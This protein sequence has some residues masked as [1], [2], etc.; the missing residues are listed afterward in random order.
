MNINLRQNYGY[1]I[2]QTILIVAVIA[3]LVT[4]IIGSVA[5]DMLSRAGG[6]K[7]ASHLRQFETANGQFYAKYT[8][9]PHQAASTNSPDGIFKTLMDEAA[10]ESTFRPSNGGPDFENYI[11][12]YTLT[13]GPV[14]HTFGAGGDVTMDLSSN[15]GITCASGSQNYLVIS[16]TNVPA[17]EFME[18]DESLDGF[19]DCDNGR[20]QCNGNLLADTAVDLF[21][22][23]NSVR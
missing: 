12:S 6:T 7:L 19:P 20:L 13:G 1:T 11:P 18:T 21:Y 15:L 10:L 5:W 8:V 9:W 17:Q 23:A 4:L 22:C 2:D 16:M 3:L 14:Q